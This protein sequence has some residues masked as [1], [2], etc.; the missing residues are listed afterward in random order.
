MASFA[1]SNC[2]FRDIQNALIIQ[3]A[4]EDV[5]GQLGVD[6]TEYGKQSLRGITN[7]EIAAGTSLSKGIVAQKNQRIGE[8]LS[9]YYN[10]ASFSP[11]MPE[12]KGRISGLSSSVSS[13]SLGENA[14]NLIAWRNAWSNV[15]KECDEFLE[16]H[17]PFEIVYDTD[18]KQVGNINYESG[19]I[20]LSFS[21]MTRP[22]DGF[23]MIDDVL[24][25]LKKTGRQEEWGFQSWPFK[26]REQTRTAEDLLL[27]ADGKRWENPKTGRYYIDLPENKLINLEIVLL[28]DR[29]E[30]IA[31]INGRFTCR[32]G[33]MTWKN[34]QWEIN[35]RNGGI[36]NQHFATVKPEEIMYIPV[37]NGIDVNKI[38]D[39]LTIKILSIDDIDVESAISNGYI[40]ISTGKVQKTSKFSFVDF[41]NSL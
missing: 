1:P 5:A 3:E 39:T 32:Y 38:T 31:T 36:Y 35:R 20:D 2:T 12:V 28:N 19:T 30:I 7:T 29:Q 21:L 15:L 10:A 40:K 33:T 11:T 9:Y 4:F 27:Y 25:G 41:W 22:T 37:F 17:I 23:K 13:G 18:L 6:L 26:Q 34:E 16:S 24:K 8:A 14:R